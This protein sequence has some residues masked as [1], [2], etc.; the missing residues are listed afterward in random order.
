MTLAEVGP[1][2]RALCFVVESRGSDPAAAPSFDFFFARLVD[3]WAIYRR[4]A[5][6]VTD[7][8]QWRPLDDSGGVL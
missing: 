5:Q 1:C 3:G 6:T 7:T 2:G 8:F 4:R